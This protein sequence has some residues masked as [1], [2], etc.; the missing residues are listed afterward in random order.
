MIRA[1]QQRTGSVGQLRK[2]GGKSWQ[3]GVAALAA[4]ILAGSMIPGAPAAAEDT[5]QDAV[6]DQTQ[7]PPTE[8]PTPSEEST[9]PSQLTTDEPAPSDDA[10]T[11]QST[12][13]PTAPATDGQLQQ[14]P[15]DNTDE[16]A[17]AEASDEP[18]VIVP[19]SIQGAVATV[20]SDGTDTFDANN[21]PGN[22]Q[23]ANNGIVRTNDEIQY[24][25][26]YNTNAAV[27]TPVITS[28]APAGTQWIAVPPTCVGPGTTPHPSGIYDSVTGQP[29]GDRRLLVCQLVSQPDSVSD[30]ILPRLKVSTQPGQGTALPV[31]FMISD[32]SGDAPILSNEVSTTVSAAPFYDLRKLGR[33]ATANV[34]GPNGE[35][36][37]MNSYPV[38]ITV[39]HPTRFGPQQGIKGMSQLSNTVTFHDDLTQYSRGARL[40][41]WAGSGCGYI[42]GGDIG[43]VPASRIG[44]TGSSTATNSVPNSGTISCAANGQGFD[45]TFTG[46]DTSASSFPTTNAQGGTLGANYLFVATGIMRVWL[47][48]S[49]VVNGADGIPGTGDDNSLLLTNTVSQFDP[50]DT[51]GQ[52]NYGTGSEALTTCF[53]R[54]LDRCDNTTSFTLTAGMGMS[55]Q[56]RAYAGGGTPPGASGLWTGDLRAGL[57]YKVT[58][59]VAITPAVLPALNART[60]DIFDRSSQR[61]VQGSGA[62]TNPASFGQSAGADPVLPG[63]YLIEYGAGTSQPT[64]FA[65]MR[66]ARCDDGD[67]VWSASPTSA[68]LGGSLTPNG[69]RDTIDR[70]RITFSRDLAPQTA[71]YLYTNLEVYSTSTLDPAQNPD[72]TILSN[73]GQFKYGETPTWST[74]NTYNP[75]NHTG[76]QMGDRI[77][78]V[79]GEVR[80]SKEVR[81][82]IPGSGSQVLAGQDAEFVLKP[83]ASGLIGS[84]PGTMRDVV[85]TD[86]LPTTAPRL[87]INPLSVTAPPGVVLEFCSLCN[88]SDWSTSPPDTTYG[89]RWNFGDVPSGTPLPE[90]SYQVRVPIDAANNQSYLNT[91]SIT[92]PDDPSTAAQRTATATI[93]VVA[94]ATVL[95]TKSTVRPVEPLNTDLRWTLAIRNATAVPI[96]SL[97]VI[98]ILPFSGDGRTPPSGFAGDFSAISVENLPTGLTAYVTDVPPVDLDTR[99]GIGDSRLDPGAVTDTWFVPPGTGVWA[100]TLAQLGTAGCPTAAS[101]TA[102]RFASDYAQSGVLAPNETASWDLVLTP[103]GNATGNQY[104]NRYVARVNPEVLQLPVNSPDVPIRVVAPSVSIVKDVC[105][106]EICAVDDETAWGQSAELPTGREAV[107]RLTVTNTG[108]EPGEV[109]VSDVLPTSL[110]LVSGSVEASAGDTTGFDPDWAVGTVAPGQSETLLFRAATSGLGSITNIATANIVDRFDQ[111]ATDDD[112]ALIT[113][114]AV[115]IGLTK[116]LTRNTVGPDGIGELTYDI[117]VSNDTAYPSTYSLADELRFGAGIVITSAVASNVTPGDIEVNENWNGR[118]VTELT[119]DTPIEAT[120]SH[121]YQVVVAVQTPGGLPDDQRECATGGGAGGFLNAAALLDTDPAVTASDCDS[122]PAGTLSVTKTGAAQV[123][124]GGLVTW[125]I[126]VENTGDIDAGAFVISDEL[127]AGITLDSASDDAEVNGQVVTWRFDGLAV[128]ASR[129][130]TVSGTVDASLAG[131]AVT[132]CAA[133]SLPEGWFDP[134]ISPADRAALVAAVATPNC[135]ETEVTTDVPPTVPPTSP[136]GPGAGGSGS[137]LAITG[138]AESFVA[139]WG[140]VALLLAGAA[141]VFGS[142]RNRSRGL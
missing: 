67:A 131:K 81:E 58:S 43:G 22:D 28:T 13:Q 78:F 18:G 89:L 4:V 40:Y 79:P 102:I 69:F 35:P 74:A 72:G 134:E 25:F 6:V 139:W 31:R 136:P 24:K 41:D 116:T 129:T 65:G 39:A 50:T 92:S 94:A 82:A 63:Q 48:Q 15:P 30:S 142:R 23:A 130:V 7:T 83:S 64:T 84:A 37:I 90:L 123:E 34:N 112:D 111:S 45:M 21:D 54:P 55:K 125:S 132:N 93:S 118:D 87:A 42:N 114:V 126:R 17:P 122:A 119:V 27:I 52:S 11:V 96:D 38:G 29:G 16:A 133:T 86:I 71:F 8:Q 113:V 12:V 73:F 88:G 9:T 121:T 103:T 141:L 75:V 95:A 109:T 44:I 20:Q 68:T 105:I 99:D 77:L 57:G 98:D 85:V 100:C 49:D 70:V 2:I 53:G 140:V 117:E 1:R 47:P 124:A 120:S 115:P 60:C 59:R 10:P 19:F 14:L 51:T 66:A 56:Y 128:G 5:G 33:A 135:A 101:V 91:V 138:A 61:L 62:N 110:S 26:E 76:A 137:G 104:T 97:D 36:G 3:R 107:Y 80:V 127:P 106:T 108:E 32:A 46:M